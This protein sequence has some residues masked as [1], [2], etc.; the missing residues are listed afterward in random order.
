MEIFQH[1]NVAQQYLK[2]CNC[3]KQKQLF[4]AQN[5]SMKQSAGRRSHS[6]LTLLICEQKCR[7]GILV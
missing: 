2:I 3:S 1:K 4:L 6:N 5:K 7:L